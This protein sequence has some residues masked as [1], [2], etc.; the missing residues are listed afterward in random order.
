MRVLLV[1]FE[2]RFIKGA[3]VAKQQSL[4]FCADVAESFGLR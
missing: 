2:K 4:E 1:E 3:T